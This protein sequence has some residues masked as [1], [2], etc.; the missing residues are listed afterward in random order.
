M[1]LVTWNV[2]GIRARADQV[3]SLLQAEQPDV[4]CLQ[5]LKAL[6]AQSPLLSASATITGPIGTAA[7]AT[8]G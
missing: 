3:T 6:P 1:K 2:N 7:R 8:Q 5:E 4:L